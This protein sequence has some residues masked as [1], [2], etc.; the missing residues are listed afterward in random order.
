MK[1]IIIDDE[2]QAQSY[3][4]TL[5]LEINPEIQILDICSNLPQ[6]V[7]SIAQY[8]P[9]VVFLDI[10]M[11]RF[12]GLEITQFIEKENMN[13]G[14]I[15]TTAYDQYAIEAFKTNA[16]DYL[17][18][19]IDREELKDSLDRYAVKKDMY[20]KV[21]KALQ[22]VSPNRLI[23]PAGNDYQIIY[24]SEILFLKAEGSYTIVYLKDK[25]TFTASR[26][27]K[28]FEKNLKAHPEFVRCHK[29]YIVNVNEIESISRADGGYITLKSGNQVPLS[30]DKL[31]ELFP[32]F[33]KI[34]RN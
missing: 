27:L 12:N 4:Q 5:L 2:I 13:F 32:F 24:L 25:S 31:S 11:P 21:S 1:V 23:I 16:I 15:F 7:Y 17:L 14:I 30:L 20:S 29:S 33:Q 22:N 18:K 6:G 10:E 26:L 3:L 8:Q 9:D 19:P 28:N 34:D